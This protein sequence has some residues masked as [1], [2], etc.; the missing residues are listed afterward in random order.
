MK[1]RHT[2]TNRILLLSLIVALSTLTAHAQGFSNPKD[3][4]NDTGASFSPQMAVDSSGNINI[5]WTDMTPGNDAVF[6]SRSTTG[7]ASF[8]TPKNLSSNTGN[9]FNPEVTVDGSGNIDVVWEDATPGNNE[10]LF[11]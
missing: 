2:N 3:I 1:K 7:G 11:S 6:F 4:S 9:S 10:I 8:S 5:V